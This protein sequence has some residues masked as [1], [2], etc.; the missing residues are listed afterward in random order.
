M[1]LNKETELLT[2]SW[3]IPDKGNMEIPKEFLKKSSSKDFANK[4]GLKNIYP[5]VI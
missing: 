1:P 5:F 4:W 3:M 2:K